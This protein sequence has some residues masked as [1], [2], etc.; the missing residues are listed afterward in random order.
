MALPTEIAARKWSQSEQ[1]LANA[2]ADCP[3]TLEFLCVGTI[4]A[5]KQGNMHLGFLPPPLDGE[6]YDN[7]KRIDDTG[8]TEW[9]ALH[10]YILL[11]T[12]GDETGAL[13]MFRRSSPDDFGV[14]GIVQLV[15]ADIPDVTKPL[16]DQQL[17]FQDKVFRIFE[18][19]TDRGDLAGFLHF[20]SI[21]VQGYFRERP[22]HQADLGDVQYVIAHIPWGD[23]AEE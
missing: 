9:T 11:G 17:I 13:E 14:R 23:P 6:H 20:S 22:D 3:G 18:E 5:A 21:I 12:P 8:K 2:I 16:P 10:P 1:I 4:E 15:F 19:L 7:Q